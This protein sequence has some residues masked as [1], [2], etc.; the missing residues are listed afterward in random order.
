MAYAFG[1]STQEQEAMDSEF[2]A[3]LAYKVRPCPKQASVTH[4]G[5]YRCYITEYKRIKERIGSFLRGE[6]YQVSAVGGGAGGELI[7]KHCLVRTE[8]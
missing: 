3:N 6:Q 5:E 1:L 2:E 4:A 8:D 7:W